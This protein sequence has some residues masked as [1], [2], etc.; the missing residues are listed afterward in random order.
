MKL[1]IMQFSSVR[2]YFI[3]LGSK[4]SP[5]QNSIK[6]MAYVDLKACNYNIFN[7]YLI[8]YTMGTGG[9]FSGD[10]AAGASS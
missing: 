10:K 7:I 6:G 8:S 2:Y 4:H 1:L 3:P 5:Q 9:F